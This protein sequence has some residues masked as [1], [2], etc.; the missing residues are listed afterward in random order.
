MERSYSAADE[1]L[2]LEACRIA[3]RLEKL[4]AL[5]S[6]DVEEWA[7]IRDARYEGDDTVLVINTAMSEARLQAVAL[8][9]IVTTLRTAEGAPVEAGDAVD[10]VRRRR[11]AR[12]SA[13]SA[14]T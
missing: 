12:R 10:E 1:T 4:D 9:Q 5:L 11:E 3:D 6:G 8:R 14:A 13:R 7:R 2:V